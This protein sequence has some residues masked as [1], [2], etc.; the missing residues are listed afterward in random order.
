MTS[1]PL[2]RV[3]VTGFGPFGGAGH[4]PAQHAVRA[5]ASRL[6]RCAHLTTRILPVEYGAAQ[7]ELRDLIARVRP[8]VIVCFGLAE[9]RSSIT[10]ERV[11]L[12]LAEAR[13]ADNAGAQPVDEPL[14]A[15][16]PPALFSTLPLGAMIRA[17]R[18]TG[19]PAQVS[20]SAGT[21]VCNAVMFAA[22]AAAAPDAVAGFVHVPQAD[23]AQPPPDVPQPEA[24]RPPEASSPDAAQ[25]PPAPA[26]ARAAV[27]TL[28]Q[29]VID[30]AAVAV[31]RAAIEHAGRAP[32]AGQD[33][34]SA[35][36]VA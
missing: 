4:N 27:P 10:P 8:A 19:A 16:G 3:L 18:E 26:E 32:M 7:Q 22:L 20:Y 17:V 23:E 34:G 9:G 36:A 12:N 24:S 30:D 35:G 15:G 14:L 33:P 6:A 13:I 21:F 28:P 11:A 29:A 2:P 5:I 31:V 1:A 25:P